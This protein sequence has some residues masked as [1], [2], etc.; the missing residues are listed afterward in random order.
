M[1]KLH[2]TDYTDITINTIRHDA[3]IHCHIDQMMQRELT[4]SMS[5]TNL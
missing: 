2:A 4:T 5:V 3:A 1:Y